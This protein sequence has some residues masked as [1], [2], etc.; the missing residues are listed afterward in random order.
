M[1]YITIFLYRMQVDITY[2][3]IGLNVILVEIN[4]T[5]LIFKF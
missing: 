3:D 1:Y 4:F 5:W 2:L